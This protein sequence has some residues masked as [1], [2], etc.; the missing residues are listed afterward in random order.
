MSAQPVL[1][2]VN[3][4]TFAWIGV[5]GDSNAAAIRTPHGMLVIDT[6]QTARL[7]Q[8]W[9]GALTAETGLPVTRVVNTHCHLDHTAG[10][11][12]FSDVSIMAHEKTLLM[13]RESLGPLDGRSWVLP[14]FESTAKL[15]W[16]QN[17]LE[18]VPP[19]TPALDWFRQRISGP[20]YHDM[21][22]APP[23][24][25]FADR[26]EFLLPDEV[27]RLNYWGPAHCDGDIVV[28]LVQRKVVILGD[29]LFCGRFPWMGDCDLDGWIDQLGR[30]LTLD[31][32]VVI[33]GHGPPAT[34]AEVES[35]RN[36]LVA[37]RGSVSA[38]IRLGH[39][40]DAAMREVRLPEFAHLPRYEEW[41]STN[42]KVAFRF[43][44]SGRGH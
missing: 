22:I 31:V 1:R 12:V 21:R 10:N 19:G 41:I 5:G 8:Q 44:R 7:A 40:E 11:I 2:R 43:L 25:I 39:S 28:H 15:L 42:V 38:A 4:I 20:D 3:D 26:F 14:D 18:L 30:I 17:L 6:Q 27:V 29:L 13:L 16:G 35:F 34:L 32:E 23:T 36:L 37:L 24:E 9:R 33:P